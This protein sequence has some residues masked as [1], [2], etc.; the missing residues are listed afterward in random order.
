VFLALG[1]VVPCAR[2][3][4]F[5]GC[6]VASVGASQIESTAAEVRHTTTPMVQLGARVTAELEPVSGLT[7]H[8]WLEAAAVLTRTALV[9]SGSTLWAAWPVALS[10]G[11][12]VE[13]RFSS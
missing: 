10:G 13:L 7:V 9:S 6:A 12:L 4:R 5:N 2:V 1:S 3:G 11:L 8:P